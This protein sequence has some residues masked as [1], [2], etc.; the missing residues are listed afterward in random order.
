[1][2]L[3][4]REFQRLP[5]FERA[6]KKL[7]PQIQSAVDDTLRDLCANPV[8]PGRKVKRDK[9]DREIWTARVNRN[10][11]LSFELTDG[12]CTL[13]NVDSHDELYAST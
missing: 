13:R 2:T 11:R 6:Y 12:I 8:P 10:Y 3:G 5:R 7:T 9:A 1:M 4:I